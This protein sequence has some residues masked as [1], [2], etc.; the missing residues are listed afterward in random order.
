[1]NKVLNIFI[2]IKKVLFLYW[3]YMESTGENSVISDR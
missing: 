1:M 3:G 2:N